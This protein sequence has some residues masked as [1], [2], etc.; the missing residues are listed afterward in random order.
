MKVVRDPCGEY[1]DC[2]IRYLD[3][4]EFDDNSSDEVFFYGYGSITKNGVGFNTEA[5]DP[6]NS[7]KRKVLWQVEQPCGFTDN[8]PSP[9]FHMN[10]GTRFDEVYSND[11]LTADWLNTV[12]YDDARYK[13]TTFP[14]NLKYAVTEDVEREFDV[15][16]WGGAISQ[17]HSAMVE[18]MSKFKYHWFTLPGGGGSLSQYVSAFGV[19]R[20]HMWDILRKTKIMISTNVLYLSPQHI[21]NIKSIPRWEENEAFSH[22][23]YG[24]LPQ[25]KTRAVEAA[26]NKTLMLMKKDPWGILDHWF[27]PE[28]EFV[29]YDSNEDLEVTIQEILNN[30]DHY[31]GVANAAYERAVRDYSTERIFNLVKDGKSIETL[32]Q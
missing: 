19:D 27:V 8:P 12:K 9:M 30:W 31:E 25:V 4:E 32:E 24:I 21:S 6:Y 26:F 7:Y 20:P 2:A 1:S 17:D 16:T 22:V 3:Y 15:I 11:P 10:V 18:A 14:H 28:E 29:Y 23:D 5:L 13:I